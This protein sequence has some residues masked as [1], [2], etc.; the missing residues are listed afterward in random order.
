[1]RYF[2]ERVQQGTAGEGPEA[3]KSLMFSRKWKGGVC[4]RGE[5][6]RDHML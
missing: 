1:M 4:A 5:N 3:V 6:E 2:T